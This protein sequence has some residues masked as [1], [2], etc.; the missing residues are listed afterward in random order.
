[1]I[2]R[3]SEGN[4]LFLGEK[5]QSLSFE[6]SVPRRTADPEAPSHNLYVED[7]HQSV[8]ELEK[9]KEQSSVVSD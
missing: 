4:S 1:M 7:L 6:H 9:T 3:Q 2:R 8:N 5:P